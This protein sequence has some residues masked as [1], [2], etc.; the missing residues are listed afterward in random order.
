MFW[1][2]RPCVLVWGLKCFET[3]EQVQIDEGALH[4]TRRKEQCTSPDSKGVTITEVSS[5]MQIS[6]GMVCRTLCVGFH[7]HKVC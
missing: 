1:C 2:S 4:I 3:A 6:C 7:L 5:N